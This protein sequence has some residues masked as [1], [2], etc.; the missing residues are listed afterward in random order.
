MIKTKLF[1]TDFITE[2]PIDEQINDFLESTDRKYIDVKF[3]TDEAKSTSIMVYS[4]LLVYEE[5]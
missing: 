4:A 1:F 3:N 5:H 2:K